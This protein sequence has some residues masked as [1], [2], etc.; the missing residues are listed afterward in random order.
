MHDTSMHP[1]HPLIFSI[2]LEAFHP[3]FCHRISLQ[4]ADVV[5]VNRPFYKLSLQLILR[6]DDCIL[7]ELQDGRWIL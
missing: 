5:E 1:C 4:S 3:H 6:L 2:P 7:D